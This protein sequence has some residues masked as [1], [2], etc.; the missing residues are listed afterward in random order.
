MTDR[1]IPLTVNRLGQTFQKDN[2]ETQSLLV[3]FVGS[4]KSRFS[5]HTANQRSKGVYKLFNE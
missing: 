5:L 4:V 3:K 2:R 1:S